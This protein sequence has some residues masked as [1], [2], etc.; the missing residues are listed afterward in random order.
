MRGNQLP[1]SL[2][3]LNRYYMQESNI[4]KPRKRSL[5]DITLG[6]LA[7]RLRKA[8]KIKADIQSGAYQ[9]DSQKI[10]SAILNEKD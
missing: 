1:L 3:V 5:T 8:E 10:A 9:I 2:K 7:E 6:W 4:E